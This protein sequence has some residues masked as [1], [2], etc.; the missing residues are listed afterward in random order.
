MS[1]FGER[2]RRP[3]PDIGTI[4]S[5]YAKKHYVDTQDG[6]ISEALKHF[7]AQLVSELSDYV[8]KHYVDTQDGTISEALKH[9]KAQLVSELSDYVKKHY[10]DAQDGTISEALKYFK[11]QLVSDLSEYAKKDYV[12][13]QDSTISEALKH[14]KAQL[15]SDLSDYVKK[16]YVDAQDSTISEALKHFK[17][18][19]VSDLSD[20][21]KKHYV[22]AQDGT[23]SEALK[24]FKAQHVSDL[25]EYAKKDYVDAQ[26]GT[27]SEALKHFKAQHV[28]DLSEYAKKD[29]VDAQDGTISEALKHFKAQLVSDLSEYAKKDYVDAQDALRVLK[30]GDTMTGDLT[31]GAQSRVR[32]LPTSK[33]GPRLQGDEAISHFETVDIIKKVLNDFRYRDGPNLS[34]LAGLAD[35]AR[36]IDAQYGPVIP[37][38]ADYAR[39]KD[40][41]DALNALKTGDTMFKRK[42]LITVWA[43]NK[44]SMVDKRYEWSFGSDAARGYANGGYPMLAAGRVLRMGL[45]TTAPHNGVSD[46][47]VNISV[48]GMENKSYGATRLAGQ[49]SGV[50]IFE[51]PLELDQGDT[52]NFKSVTHNPKIAGATVSLLI[53]LDL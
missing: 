34:G 4:L 10:V 21:V 49:I 44:R 45:S 2:I 14:F 40:V 30:A 12:D 20:Y 31:M 23:I 25:S 53:E 42:P 28:S 1:I 47:G 15:V 39:K 17:A 22:D 26:D 24:H 9:F 13:A 48:N 41:Q 50:S 36:K 7:K 37:G 11:A 29:Y 8:K 43:E 27:I 46:A 52:I 3:E 35:Y 6:T 5:D 19:L 51:T 32:G 16:H 33:S 38:L 18:Q